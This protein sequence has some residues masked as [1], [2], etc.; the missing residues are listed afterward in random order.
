MGSLDPYPSALV[1]LMLTVKVG[2]T[3]WVGIDPP[4][5]RNYSTNA[6][7]W[8]GRRFTSRVYR[9]KSGEVWTEV[10]RVR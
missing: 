9:L 7:K 8:T 1:K 2:D 6:H 4:T 5:F 10:R 3:F